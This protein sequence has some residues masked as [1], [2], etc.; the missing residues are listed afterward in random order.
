[1]S[2][3]FFRSQHRRSKSCPSRGACRKSA[4]STRHAQNM[5]IW[6]AAD[7]APADL[8]PRNRAGKSAASRPGEEVE[9]ST[10][11]LAS[12]PV[13]SPRSCRHAS[14]DLNIGARNR[15]LLAEHVVNPRRQLAMLK[16]WRFGSPPMPHRQTCLRE[17]GPENPQRRVQVKKLSLQLS[18][19]LLPL[20]DLQ[21]HVGTLLPI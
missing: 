5:A 10:Q 9:P 7:A 14:S 4:P 17:I 8:P 2:A 12:P 6:F 15:A 20:F 1:M 16:I 13:R 3:R 11:Q 21:D 19:S 18:N